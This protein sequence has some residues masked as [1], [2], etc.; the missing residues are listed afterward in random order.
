MAPPETGAV[1]GCAGLGVPVQPAFARPFALP[2]AS[3][4][5]DRERRLHLHLQRR[6]RRFRQWQARPTRRERRPDDQRPTCRH[7]RFWALP[8]T[9]QTTGVPTLVFV[10][11]MPGQASLLWSPNTPGIV[12]QETRSLSSVNFVQFPGRRSP[13][14]HPSRFGA[15]EVLPPVKNRESWE[16]NVNS[17][18][19]RRLPGFEFCGGTLRVPMVISRTARLFSFASLHPSG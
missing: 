17:G 16:P 14:R 7:R 19:Q 6:R 4:A 13:S 5:D 2:L 18:N 10:P 1:P 12:L 11:A 9:V 3:R 15:E 8:Q